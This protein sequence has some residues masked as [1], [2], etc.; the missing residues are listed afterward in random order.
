MCRAPEHLPF[1]TGYAWRSLPAALRFG[2]RRN[3]SRMVGNP[4]LTGLGKSSPSLGC[5]RA[6]PD[7]MS[8]HWKAVIFN[9]VTHVT[10]LCVSYRV[11]YNCV[12]VGKNQSRDCCGDDASGCCHCSGCAVSW[13]PGAEYPKSRL[14]PIQE[15]SREQCCYLLHPA[16]CC[17]FAECCCCNRRGDSSACCGRPILGHRCHPIRS[18]SPTRYIASAMQFRPENLAHFP[19]KVRAGISACV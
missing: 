16:S 11:A 18:C 3:P 17:Y 1:V 2:T 4:S 19:S 13:L 14:L 8:V 5:N 9:P 6:N 15:R 12:D 7:H 10:A